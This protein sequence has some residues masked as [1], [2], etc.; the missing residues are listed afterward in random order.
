MV[1]RLTDEAWKRERRR[2]GHEQKG[3]ERTRQKGA[4]I[5][6][7]VELRLLGWTLAAIGE[8]LGV[9]KQRVAAICR[10][11]RLVERED[12]R[13]VGRVVCQCDCA[14]RCDVMAFIS[15][16][17]GLIRFEEVVYKGEHLREIARGRSPA[18]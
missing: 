14:D 5:Y 13:F 10:D 8:E 12:G 9:S 15:A 6:R 7:A 2:S 4:M 16:K 18:R 3:W 17:R 1:Y 11:Y